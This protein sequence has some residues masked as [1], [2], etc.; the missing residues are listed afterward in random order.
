MPVYIVYGYT[1]LLAHYN[2]NHSVTQ[3]IIS[4]QQ[5]SSNSQHRNTKNY[6]SVITI[7]EI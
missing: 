6:N 3:K 1:S 4:V 7:T 2:L 5:Q